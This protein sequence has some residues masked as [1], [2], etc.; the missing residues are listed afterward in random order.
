MSNMRRTDPLLPKALEDLARLVFDE[1]DL[2]LFDFFW[3]RVGE[4]NYRN[5]P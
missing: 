1:L 3:S 4:H 2:G 5:A